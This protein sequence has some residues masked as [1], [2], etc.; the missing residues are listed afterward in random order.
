MTDALAPLPWENADAATH[1]PPNPRV[2][3]DLWRWLHLFLG[4][5]IVALWGFAVSVEHDACDLAV[6]IVFALV[7][8]AGEFALRRNRPRVIATAW[9]ILLLASFLA[10]VLVNESAAFLAFPLYFVAVHCSRGFRAAGWVFGFTLCAVVGIAHHDG[11]QPGAIVGPVIA[12]LIVILLGVGFQLLVEEARA[13]EVAMNEVISARAEAT[14]LAR[15]A[16]EASE[17]ARVAAEIH[18]TVAQGL[19]SIQL[20]LHAAEKKTTDAAVQ[21][22]IA[23]ARE[24]AHAN[25][26]ETRRIIAALQPA[27]LTGASLPVALARICSSTPMQDRLSFA[28]DGEPR[29]LPAEVEA[30]LVR[31][32]Q[33]L[34]ANVVRHAEADRAT[35]TLTYQPDSVTLDVVDGGKGFEPADVHGSFGLSAARR[36]VAELGGTLEIESAPGAGTGVQVF[37]PLVEEGNA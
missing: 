24:T 3:H 17:R 32:A 5:L 10:F 29:S 18:D 23:L 31:V 22:K 26:Q 7:F 34:V 13:R 15:E 21:H 30:T 2:L 35:V 8:G 20:L 6:A 4:A 12:G 9:L 25:L 27:P 37:I 36:R 1:R 11:W 14:Q 19:S 33:S 28:V 16:G